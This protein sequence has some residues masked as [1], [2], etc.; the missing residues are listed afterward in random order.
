MSTK[1]SALTQATNSELADASIA[2]VVTDPSGT[3]ASKK[4]SLARLGLPA[5]SLIEE[6]RAFYGTPASGATNYTNGLTFRARRSGQKCI[7]VRVYW[8]NAAAT[9]LVLKLWPGAAGAALET[10]TVAIS[11]TGYKTGLFLTQVDLDRDKNYIASCWE[12][13][14]QLPAPQASSGSGG[15]GYPL[16]PGAIMRDYIVMNWGMYESN[17]AQPLQQASPFFYLVE[18]LI[19]G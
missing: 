14:R 6:A 4:S 13:T 8:D 19:S 16:G 2:Y 1:V 17:N 7:G 11:G 3:P 12:G 15:I 10:V 9:N 18:P 5:V